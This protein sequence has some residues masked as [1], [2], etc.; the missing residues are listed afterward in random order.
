MAV[1]WNDN[2]NNKVRYQ[3]KIIQLTEDFIDLLEYLPLI[4]IAIFC[5]VLYLVLAF[6][7]GINAGI[8]KAVIY[9]VPMAI[10]G[11]IASFILSSLVQDVSKVCGVLIVISIESRFMSSA[12]NVLLMNQENL[13]ELRAFL[14]FVFANINYYALCIAA[15]CFLIRVFKALFL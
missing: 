3:G 8:T 13:F 5:I 11:R 12:V 15:I 9:L 1:I 14:V 7:Y 2:D 6:I 4:R 10:V